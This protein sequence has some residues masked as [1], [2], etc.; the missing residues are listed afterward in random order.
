MASWLKGW[1]AVSSVN[2]CQSHSRLSSRL[3]FLT[4]R[5]EGLWVKESLLDGSPPT[6]L[7]LWRTIMRSTEHRS[8]RPCFQS[9]PSPCGRA[10]ETYTLSGWLR[11]H[12]ALICQSPK[13]S[14]DFARINTLRINYE[15]KSYSVYNY[16]W[17]EVSGLQQSLNY[18]RRNVCK[19]KWPGSK[20]FKL[21]GP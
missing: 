21:Q 1:D 7:R 14:L 11:S 6:N 8:H 20:Y 18:L 9:P 17:Q 3:F 15:K 2:F 4:S 16:V 10:R 12:R 13:E 19:L 5:F